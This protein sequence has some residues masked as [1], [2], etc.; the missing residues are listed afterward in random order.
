MN[1]LEVINIEMALQEKLQGNKFE[2]LEEV[3][4]FMKT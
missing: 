3:D 1:D 2:N 4:K